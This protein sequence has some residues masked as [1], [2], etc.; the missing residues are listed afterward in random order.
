M[1]AFDADVHQNDQEFSLEINSGIKSM[2]S[3]KKASFQYEIC[4]K[5]YSS[6]GSLKRHMPRNHPSSKA[7]ET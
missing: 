4:Y 2:P 5:E 6:S 1:A 3:Q 7:Q